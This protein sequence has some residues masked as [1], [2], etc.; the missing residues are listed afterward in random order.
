MERFFQPFRLGKLTL[1]NR[2]IMAP[3]KTAYGTPEG[4]V[5]RRHLNFYN[6]VSQGGVSLIVLE[7]V[8]VL[9][10]GKEHPKQLCIDNEECASGLGKIV[11]L[12]HKNS[13]YACLNLNHAGRAAN[14]KATGENPKAPSPVPCPST[15][16]TPQELAS[17]EIEEIIEAFGIATRRAVKLGFDA[18]EIQCGHGYL[19]SQ[20]L[21]EDTN[22]RGD[23][24][25]KYP[26]LFAKKVFEEVFKH[27]QDIPV[28]MRISGSEFVE[29]GLTPQKNEKLISLAE[30][31]GAAAIHVGLG[32]ACDSPPW[33]FNHMA[34]PEEPQYKVLK[35][36]KSMTNLPLIVVGRMA[37]REKLQRIADENIGDMVAFGRPLIADPQLVNKLASGAYDA[38]VQCGYCLQGCLF[39]VRTGLGLG[40]IANPGI[41]KEKPSPATGKMKCVVVGAGPAGIMAAITLAQRGRQVKLYGKEKEPGGQFRLAPLSPLKKSMTR[42]LN[43]LIKQLERSHVKVIYGKEATFD[44]L[45]SEAPDLVVVATGSNPNIPDIKGLKT[46]YWITGID[47]FSGQK[48][49]KGERVLIIGAGMVGVE[50]AEMLSRE[51]KAVVA[52]KRTDTIANDMEPI[53]RNMMLKDLNSRNNVKL[54]PNTTVKRFTDQGV[55]VVSQGEKLLL[56]PFD[57]VILTAGMKPDDGLYQKIKGAFK[58]IELIGD[59]REPQ[60]IFAATQA[61]YEVGTKY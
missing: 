48:P 58:H 15:S 42:P 32:N 29:G 18:L 34:L 9:K 56:E 26:L 8:S 16:Q 47:F 11:E 14:P 46:Q 10:N 17:E 40:C 23:Q 20:F 45:K 53:T 55:E 39:N 27:A 6:K 30:E 22:K 37:S 24:F 35:E 51:G 28:I 44:L 60:S 59:A 25:G 2:F 1:R 61:G 7:P 3:I 19:I 13:T 49:A 57:T 12:L 38:I 41:D 4:K 31:F 33:Y 50:A 52:T 36:I 54:M 43:S 21:R 5:T